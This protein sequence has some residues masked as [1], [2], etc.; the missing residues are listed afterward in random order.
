MVQGTGMC[1]RAQLKEI[2]PFGVDWQRICG[3]EF[4]YCDLFLGLYGT[5]HG[6]KNS[7]KLKETLP[8]DMQFRSSCPSIIENDKHVLFDGPANKAIRQTRPFDF[9]EQTWVHVMVQLGYSNIG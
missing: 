6:P 2:V 7:R 8:G 1:F 5:I 9:T 4:C 3:I